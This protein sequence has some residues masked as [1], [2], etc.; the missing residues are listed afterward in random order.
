MENHD[1]VPF[2]TRP[3]NTHIGGKN[4]DQDIELS[5]YLDGQ[6]QILENQNKNIYRK[7]KN[8]PINLDQDQEKNIYSGAQGQYP[9][10]LSSIG[11]RS[12]KGFDY[13]EYEEEENEEYDPYI[14]Y[15]HKK[16]LIGKNNSRKITNYIHID[17]RQ[18]NRDTQSFINETINLDPNPFSFQG[19]F[20]KVNVND[21]SKLFPNDKISI[22]GLTEKK[23]SLRTVTRDLSGNLVRS[24]EF[25]EGQ[26]FFRINTN[27]NTNVNQFFSTDNLY[28]YD[29]I[30][31]D[32]SGFIGDRRSSWVMNIP[33]KMILQAYNLNQTPPEGAV[34]PIT[35]FLLREDVGAIL[36][37]FVNDQGEVINSDGSLS[38][39]QN[40][41]DYIYIMLWDVDATG[42]VVFA[43]NLR[44]LPYSNYQFLWR[45]TNLPPHGIPRVGAN[46]NFST[47]YFKIG[48]DAISAL[49]PLSFPTTFFEV[50]R[51]TEEVQNIIRPIFFDFVTNE[52]LITTGSNF[53]Q[54]NDNYQLSVNFT[55]PELTVT[56]LIPS[57]GNIPV[58]QIN[59]KHR[60]YFS[61]DQIIQE[62]DPIFPITENITADK[63]YIKL[64]DEFTGN[65]FTGQFNEDNTQYTFSLFEASVADIIITFSHFGGVPVNVINSDFPVGFRQRDGFKFIA[66]VIDNEYILIE[67]DRRGFLNNNF[68]G[69]DITIGIIDDIIEGSRSANDYSINL[70]KTYSN[71]IMVRMIGSIFPKSHLAIRDGLQNGT[72]NNKLYWQNYVDGSPIYSID[73]P[74]GNYSSQVL[75][76]IIEE[77]IS[78][79]PRFNETTPIFKNNN[80]KMSIDEDTD[81]VKF[82]AF[83]I[84]KKSNPYRTYA[85]ISTLN[86]ASSSE[87]QYY[88][89]PTGQFYTDF[90]EYSENRNNLKVISL[91]FPNHRLNR[92]DEI[93]LSQF[94]D[95]PFV[96]KDVINSTHIVTHVP[97][98]DPV[99]FFH[100][101]VDFT[102]YIPISNNNNKGGNTARLSKHIRFRMLFDQDDTFGTE[103]GFRDVGQSTS[104]TPYQTIITNDIVYDGET[105][106]TN[107]YTR[108]GLEVTD[109]DLNNLNIHNQ[110]SLKGPDYLIIKCEE[111]PNV[112][113]K[114]NINEYFYKIRLPGEPG[115]VEHNTFVDTPIFFTEPIRKV[116]NLTFKF[117]DPEGNLYSFLGRNHSFTIEFITLEEI[118]I[119]TAIRKK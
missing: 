47:G 52:D 30:E 118:P 5:D 36:S 20:L 79:V 115:T 55:L 65:T 50:I 41:N 26:P 63:F 86:S 104:I 6:K 84:I 82:E 48:N 114:G 25:I 88:V 68:G 78:Q 112:R 61:S 58:N 33:D 69:N 109:L 113:N 39:N 27:N 110:I 14:G 57:V 77:K 72:Q 40:R 21:T 91:N 108:L 67:L 7:K 53:L 8:Q 119:G 19:N 89:F 102:E 29:D 28:Q 12:Y 18:R 106:S 74:A 105:I 85:D 75:K 45:G 34:L 43:W 1:L 107:K 24:F 42:K 99:N 95:L 38:S 54:N 70:D 2:I 49:T 15:A 111:F 44:N 3:M 17:S 56:Q 92:K 13:R 98:N 66:D 83:D 32:I 103:L 31:V 81:I 22:G 100:I 9:N 93:I 64:N 97:E 73:V 80:I 94:T 4:K 90:P 116:E 23:I 16:G 51:F 76:N 62:T 10:S 96:P 117:Y 71:V 46:N 59:G 60:M 11:T 87:F 35:R 101:I 37:Q